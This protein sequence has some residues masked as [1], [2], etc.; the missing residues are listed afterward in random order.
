MGKGKKFFGIFFLTFIPHA[1]FK[2]EAI[3]CLHQYRAKSC[4]KTTCNVFFCYGICTQMKIAS[5]P[6]VFKVSPCAWAKKNKKIMCALMAL[7]NIF[8]VCKLWLG[9]YRSKNWCTMWNASDFSPPVWKAV[10]S[11]KFWPFVNEAETCRAESQ[12]LCEK[13]FNQYTLVCLL[14]S[15]REAW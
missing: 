11:G 3:A 6:F 8:S 2:C 5:P 13:L 4:I 15:I 1:I 12:L 10:L 7:A 14:N 9:C